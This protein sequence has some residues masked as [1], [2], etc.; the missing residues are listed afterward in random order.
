MKVLDIA[1]VAIVR[2]MGECGVDE[3]GCTTLKPILPETAEII[4]GGIAS[5]IIFAALYKFAWPQIKKA[6][7]ARTERIQKELDDAAADKASAAAEAAQIR[8]AKGDIAAERE[9]LLA[10]ADTQAAAVLEEGRARMAAEMADIEAKA[11]ADIAAANS[12]VGDEL[13]AEIARLSTAAVDHVVTGSLDEATHQELIESF[14]QKV[15][16]SR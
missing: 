2:P 16:A 15:G 7:A 8:Q 10:E 12:R 11:M 6:M 13:R 5:L 9:R 14:I 3:K 4:Y 1:A